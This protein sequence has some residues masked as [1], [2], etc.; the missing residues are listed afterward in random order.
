[1]SLTFRKVE[2]LG[3]D[4]LL[5]DRTA[6]PWD[7]L[8]AEI[9]A[10]QPLAPALCNRRT[11]V[12]G[13]GLLIVGSGP[14]GT[15]G[16]MLVINHDGSR[17][18]MCGNGL[19]CVAQ[20]LAE[21]LG[22][23]TLVV[24]TD[25]GPKTCE[26]TGEGREVE[27]GVNMGPGE[28]LGT[29]TV[30]GG[31]SYQAVSMG[32]PHAIA[33]VDEDPQAVCRTEGPAAETDAAFPDR[34]NVEFALLGDGGM[35]LWVWERGCGITQACG[36]G[37]CAAACAAVWSGRHPPDQALAVDLPGGRLWIT[38]PQNRDGGV[39]MR[40]PARIVFDGTVPRAP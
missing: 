34:T 1:M 36:T 19:R 18:E 3:N 14:E 2:G 4:F 33:F 27:V 15:D 24:Q 20:H 37:A 21:R 29:R 9:A 13:D 17:P 5:I 31:R 8:E 23:K 6:L 22:R 32:N 28:D 11:G 12:G 10:L 39:H 35:T 7:A 40:G 25:A 26:V 16:S 38:V 30:A